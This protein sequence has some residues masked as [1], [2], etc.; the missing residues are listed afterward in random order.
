MDKWIPNQIQI[1]LFL[2]EELKITSR[3][4][5]GHNVYQKHCAIQWKN[6]RR[7]SNS[8]SD[9]DSIWHCL[10]P[11]KNWK[12]IPE[13]KK[14]AHEDRITILNNHPVYG[15]CHNPLILIS[16]L[17]SACVLDKL[18]QMIESSS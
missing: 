8:S 10:I 18:E 13:E 11:F 3:Q 17:S 6:R 15:H 12:D 2:H 14:E 4:I 9:S 5:R 1:H 16:L 7:N